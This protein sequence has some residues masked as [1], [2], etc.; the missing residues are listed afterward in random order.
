MF[1][2]L[3]K[4]RFHALSVDGKLGER[5]SSLRGNAQV[6]FDFF[7]LKRSE[8]VQAFTTYVQE[9]QSDSIQLISINPNTLTFIPD[10]KWEISDQVFTI[11]TKVTVL[12][13]YDFQRDVKGI[14]PAIKAAI[15]GKNVEEARKLIL[16]YSE[17]ASTKIDLGLLQGGELPNVKSRINVKVAF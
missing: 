5:A 3:V 16:Q 12:Q 6:S 17:V 2:N 13:G 11:P 10:I 4:T 7:Y 14:I 8:I 15:A 1:D 9:R